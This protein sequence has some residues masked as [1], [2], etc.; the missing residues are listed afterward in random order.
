MH[1]CGCNRNKRKAVVM[2][3]VFTVMVLQ[4]ARVMCVSLTALHPQKLEIKPVTEYYLSLLKASSLLLKIQSSA[5]SSSILF[6]TQSAQQLPLVS[7][8]FQMFFFLSRY[9]LSPSASVSCELFNLQYLSRDSLPFSP[10]TLFQSEL[11]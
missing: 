1:T 10:H 8:S 4:L 3:R 6:W 9:A 11:S 2:I 7:F 5:V